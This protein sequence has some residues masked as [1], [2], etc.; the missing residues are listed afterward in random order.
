MAIQDFLVHEVGD[1]L[2]RK[3]TQPAAAGKVGDPGLVGDR[4]CVLL[5]DQAVDGYATCKFNGSF[6][7]SVEGAGAA[8]AAAIAIGDPVYYDAAAIVKINKDA[9]NGVRYGTAVNAVAA[10]ATA[11]IVVDLHG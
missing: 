2:Y 8:G 6:R 10:A 5:T 1:Q 7:L 9:T 3:L 11:T 4:P